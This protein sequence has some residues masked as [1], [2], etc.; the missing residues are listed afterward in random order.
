LG[1]FFKNSFR[2]HPRNE[3]CTPFDA[4]EVEVHYS[5]F[6]C[7][8][9]STESNS[10]LYIWADRATTLQLADHFKCMTKSYECLF[11]ISIGA[12][13]RLCSCFLKISTPNISIVIT[14]SLHSPHLKIS[15]TSIE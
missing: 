11:S 4:H 8:S 13:R 10:R 2:F 15:R 6:Y 5:T 14:C 3:D 1:Q 9:S 7:I 12:A